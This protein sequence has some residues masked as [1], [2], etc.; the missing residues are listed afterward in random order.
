[1]FKEVGERSL[2]GNIILG[3]YSFD[4]GKENWRKFLFFKMGGENEMYIVFV[5]FGEICFLI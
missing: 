5:L 2:N 1:M 3:N 4:K